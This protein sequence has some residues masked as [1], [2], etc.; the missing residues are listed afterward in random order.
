MGAH[1]TPRGLWLQWPW[2]DL[3]L[4]ILGITAWALLGAPLPAAET[5][6]T[7]FTATSAAAGI[8][9]AAA[10]FVCTIFYQSSN[11]LLSDIRNTY[12]PLIRRNW[13]WIL[14]CLLAAVVMPVVSIV[15]DPAAPA[16]ATAMT[17]AAG[18]MFVTSFC[19]VIY[20]FHMTLGILD[21][22]QNAPVGLHTK[23]LPD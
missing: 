2:G 23:N 10:A 12:G 1:H 22:P 8:G 5:R 18:L 20:W 16:I 7:F 17:T 6:P 13:V 14:S 21:S 15:I 9:L 11:A 19:R 4:P 3:A